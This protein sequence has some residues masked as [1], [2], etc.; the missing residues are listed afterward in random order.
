[1]RYCLLPWTRGILELQFH[2]GIILNAEKAVFDAS[3]DAAE[4]HLDFLVLL[5]DPEMYLETR[6][7]LSLIIGP[8]R[9]YYIYPGRAVGYS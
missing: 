1:M 3:F 8:D 9:S 6:P 4:D 5:L 2:L 7:T